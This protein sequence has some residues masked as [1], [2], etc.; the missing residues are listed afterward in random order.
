MSGRQVGKTNQ[1]G[2][3]TVQMKIE[4]IED[5]TTDGGG[6]WQNEGKREQWKV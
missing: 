2:T 5:Q 4:M 6:G 3:V 1:L